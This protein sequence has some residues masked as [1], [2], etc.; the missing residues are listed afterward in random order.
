[1]TQ[2]SDPDVVELTA[3]QAANP[4]PGRLEQ[5]LRAGE[6]A[7][8]TELTPPDSADPEEVYRRA[9]LFDGYVD[10]MNATDGSGANCHMSSVGV[11]ALL[12]RLGYGMVMQ[13]SC[14][15]RNRIAIQGDLLG[16]AAMGVSSVLC[17]TGDGVQVGDEPEAKPVFD[18]D[19]ISLL[20]AVRIMRDESHFL[21]GRPLDMPPRMFIGA[22]ANP[23]VAPHDYQVQR[24]EKKI[25]AGAE[26][27]QTQYCYD[28]PRL[29]QFMRAVRE[30]G[31]HRR[32]YILVG[33]G[34]PASAA[35]ADWMRQNIPGV[36][37]PDAII[38]R[39]ATASDPQGAGEQL[40]I[41]LIREL[42]EIEGIAGVHIMATRR[43]SAVPR[44]IEASGVL[45]HRKPWH[46]DHEDWI[47]QARA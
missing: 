36:H 1:M 33:V 20:R 25:A 28:I 22:A 6:F 47:E 29:K 42:S 11:C 5:I 30:R 16:A 41:E 44:I 17:L 34:V 18:F 35:S 31:L 19:S 4:P 24:L 13:V 15:D 45:A 32:A 40:C 2:H 23:F 46:P 3:M 38:E 10:A 21:T 39:L 9:R 26:F 12:T 7:V 43:E 27:I 37:I 8:T 14:R